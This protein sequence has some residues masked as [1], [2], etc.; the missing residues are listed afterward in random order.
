MGPCVE[1]SE[2]GSGTGRARHSQQGRA[3]YEHAMEY[4]KRYRA[5]HGAGPLAG[6]AASVLTAACGEGTRTAVRRCV[7]AHAAV[8]TDTNGPRGSDAGA[9]R[10]IAWRTHR[11]LSK[12]SADSAA[13]IV[14]SS[15]F[16]SKDLRL[17]WFVPLCSEMLMHRS[18]PRTHTGTAR[19]GRMGLR[20][21]GY[22]TRV[23]EGVL[24]ACPLR[25]RATKGTPAVPQC[26][27]TLNGTC[28]DYSRGQ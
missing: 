9:R 12:L 11:K 7:R 13:G 25:A 28:T 23:L 3:E 24:H 2:R 21:R 5:P 27:H 26:A 22:S 17:A 20:P 15:E 19:G 10:G 1:R 16:E 6:A 18:V 14:P 4:C 8:L